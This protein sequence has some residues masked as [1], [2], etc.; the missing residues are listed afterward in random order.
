[1][2]AIELLKNKFGVSQKY[3][4]DVMVDGEVLLEPGLSSLNIKKGMMV[5]ALITGAD[6]YENIMAAGETY[7]IAPTGPSQIRRVEAGLIFTS[8]KTLSRTFM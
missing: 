4:H 5:S 7:K 3:K 6:L 8:L 1:M 2:E